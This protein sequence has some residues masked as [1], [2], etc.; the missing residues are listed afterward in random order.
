M[1]RRE[2]IGYASANVRISEWTIQGYG[3]ERYMIPE[4]LM[5]PGISTYPL[6]KHI[7]VRHGNS[8]IGS[9]ETYL[10]LSHMILESISGSDIDLQPTLNS[11]IIITGGSSLIPGLIERLEFELRSIA[12]AMKFKISAPGNLVERK[13][14]SWLGG[15]ILGSLGSFISF[16]SGKM[17]IKNKFGFE[18]NSPI[19][20][21]QHSP[22]PSD[23]I[24]RKW[25]GSF[26]VWIHDTIPTTTTA[27]T[28]SSTP[29][30][31]N[32]IMTANSSSTL[33]LAPTQPSRSG[34]RSKHFFKPTTT[35]TSPT[36]P[37]KPFPSSNLNSTEQSATRS[38]RHPFNS[39]SKLGRRKAV[40]SETSNNLSG[41]SSIASQLSLGP[42][43][44]MNSKGVGSGQ[45]K[46]VQG[47]I[48]EDGHFTLHTGNQNEVILYRIY[49]PSYRRTDIRMVHQSI[50]GRP[51]CGVITQ[52]TGGG[53]TQSSNP[54]TS[55]T[56]LPLGVPSSSLFPASIN[57]S[58]TSLTPSTT[59]SHLMTPNTTPTNLST[60]LLKSTSQQSDSS[61][62]PPELSIYIC[63][64]NSIL[65]ES[66]LV[67]CK[68]F[69]RPD[70]F[71]H[72]Y[73][74][75]NKKNQKGVVSKGE[76]TTQPSGL[77]PP[78][79]LS[80]SPKNS[81][82]PERVRIWRGIEIQLLEVHSKGER[83]N[84]TGGFSANITTTT[85]TT[86]CLSPSTVNKDS[87]QSSNFSQNQTAQQDPPQSQQTDHQSKLYSQRFT[88][89]K[90]GIEPQS[91]MTGFS[92]SITSN[93]NQVG[94]QNPGSNSNF[95]DKPG[96][97]SMIITPSNDSSK[98]SINSFSINNNNNSPNDNFY[99]IE[100]DWD[101]EVIGRSTIKRNLNPYW[102]E[103][104]KFSEL[105]SFKTPLIMN[106]YRIKR[107]FNQQQ[108]QQQTSSPSSSTSSIIT[109]IGQTQL[110]LKSFEKNI[111][112]QLWLPIYSNPNTEIMGE[113]NLSITVVEQ[114]VL[115]EPEYAKMMVL[116][117]N[118][119]DVEL[120]LNLANMAV[121]ELDRLAELLI[122][123]YESS[124]RLYIRFSQLAAIEINGDLSTASILFRAN[125]L[126]TKM[127][128]A[129]MRIVG[130]SFLDQALE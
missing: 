51:H 48:T 89:K 53:I 97:S 19:S 25:S 37:P 67:I 18:A 1:G 79:N 39:E 22:A 115:A 98:L 109:L 114:V 21:D 111:Q 59:S 23:Q 83:R 100:F 16:G 104:F 94:V 91:S 75:A 101:N 26:Y 47:V 108:Q 52:K 28:I 124:D 46:L 10:P 65:L 55:S 116:L 126:L 74:R 78:K 58:L 36:E 34:G 64:P 9:S 38:K 130:R 56:S 86:G 99:F 72:L 73:P 60:P 93:L 44:A 120:P 85:T 35:L 57:G 66:W 32:S 8:T 68:C 5:N 77:S 90:I 4:I 15:S 81:S 128:E 76:D 84:S 24:Y 112:L 13:F 95:N 27:P 30:D 29:S 121:G 71:R 88:P 42:G 122:R 63:M 129:Y 69:C 125:T 70:D 118:D 54:L 107:N 45:W 33:N 11:N 87:S 3:R 102:S 119:E 96:S 2:C 6:S 113:I 12:P 62:A 50:F 105:G 82:P 61:I 17:S 92:S 43:A 49:L 40:P 110:D 20:K 7:G 80:S 127:L 41:T 106:V 31:S 14:S 117:N 103:S 123:I